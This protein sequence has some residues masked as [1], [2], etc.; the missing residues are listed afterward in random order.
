MHETRRVQGKRAVSR[1]VRVTSLF[2]KTERLVAAK[3]FAAD[4]ARQILGLRLRQDAADST[5]IRQGKASK[6]HGPF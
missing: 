1:T 5:D 2:A 4:V 6:Y 3:R